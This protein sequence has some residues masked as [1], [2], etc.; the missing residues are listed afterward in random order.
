MIKTIFLYKLF[1]SFENVH[2]FLITIIFCLILSYS[3]AKLLL[4]LGVKSKLWAVISVI[5]FYLLLF[6][7][8]IFINVLF[9][10]SLGFSIRFGGFGCVISG[11]ISYK[12]IMKKLI[13]KGF[14]VEKKSTYQVAIDNLKDID[15]KETIKPSEYNCPACGYENSK[16]DI[17]CNDCGLRLR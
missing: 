10:Y 9:M 7:A 6:F 15:T 12:I 16:N 8:I 11:I 5:I 2:S 17:N 14:I 1:N 13:K 3:V 4:W